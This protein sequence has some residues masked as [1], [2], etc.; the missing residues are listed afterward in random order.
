MFHELWEQGNQDTQ[1]IEARELAEVAEEFY[2]V[3]E[4][5]TALEILQQAILLLEEKRGGE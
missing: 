1:L 2:L 5:E 4:Y 3:A